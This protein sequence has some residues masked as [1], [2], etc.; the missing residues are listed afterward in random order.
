MLTR[1]AWVLMFNDLSRPRNKLLDLVKAMNEYKTEI[2][3]KCV[4][5]EKSNQT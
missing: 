3:E 1:K 5:S 2:R 4:R